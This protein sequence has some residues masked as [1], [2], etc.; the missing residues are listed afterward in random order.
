MLSKIIL[1]ATCATI[2]VADDAQTQPTVETVA[3]NVQKA[4]VPLT[5]SDLQQELLGMF[6]VSSNA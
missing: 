3:Q 5:V 2:I 4:P 6:L 1:L